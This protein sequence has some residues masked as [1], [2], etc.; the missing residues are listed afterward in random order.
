MRQPTVDSPYAR[1]SCTE[2]YMYSFIPFYLT[3]GFRPPPSFRGCHT[4]RLSVKAQYASNGKG[5]G[6]T[7]RFTGGGFSNSGFFFD[8]LLQKILY[9]LNEMY[10][11]KSPAMG[12]KP[13]WCSSWF[14][15]HSD[16]TYIYMVIIPC[17]GQSG[18]FCASSTKIS[19][20]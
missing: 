12:K 5:V 13:H 11:N 10:K 14:Y 19:I 16:G 17:R 1:T 2:L 6:K 9:H 4:P 3:I 20:T 18:P 8:I 15:P 7:R